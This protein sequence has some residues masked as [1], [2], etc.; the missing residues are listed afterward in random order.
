[1]RAG[2]DILSTVHVKELSHT[3]IP[4]HRGLLGNA[5]PTDATITPR[6]EERIDFDESISYQLLI[7]GETYLVKK[8]SKRCMEEVMMEMMSEGRVGIKPTL[9]E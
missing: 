9:T 2:E 3:G 8:V 5:F 1:M 4:S 6:L 7:Q